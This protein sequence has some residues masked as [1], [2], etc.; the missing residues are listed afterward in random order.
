[1]ESMTNY[2]NTAPS[3]KKTLESLVGDA[4][5]ASITND[6]VFREIVTACQRILEITDQQLGDALHVSRPTVNR[7]INGKSIPQALMRKSI[8]NWIAGQAARKLRILQEVEDGR[9]IAALDE[10]YDMVAKAR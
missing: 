9:R 3:R 10:S 6:A 5:K 2:I 8:F 4:R 1:M 7:W